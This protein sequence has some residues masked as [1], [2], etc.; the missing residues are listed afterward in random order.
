MHRELRNASADQRPM[1][2][3]IPDAYFFNGL[4]HAGNGTL[5]ETLSEEYLPHVCE[6]VGSQERRLTWEAKSCK[7]DLCPAT[8]NILKRAANWIKDEEPADTSASDS[9][10]IGV[11]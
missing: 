10:H 6:L 7:F 4:H 1:R 11:G 9:P 2:E 3:F 8:R 5:L